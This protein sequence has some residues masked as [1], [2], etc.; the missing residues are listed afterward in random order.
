MA[1]DAGEHLGEF[2]EEYEI[3]AI[4]LE[5]IKEF[6]ESVQDRIEIRNE[7][8]NTIVRLPIRTLVRTVKGLIKNGLD[9]SDE[10]SPVFLRCFCDEKFLYFE[11]KDQGCGMDAEISARATEPF[12]TT[13]E[14]GRGLG[15]GLF[16]AQNLA[17]QF[18]GELV[19]DSK[20]QGGTTVTISL[21]LEKIG[22]VA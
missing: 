19:I 13:K 22:I 20:K 7:A 11:V 21:A 14:P 10:V 4:L 8:A 18:G 17:E 15:L 5:I 9:A 1:A 2:L 3:D 16:L 12:F 6:P